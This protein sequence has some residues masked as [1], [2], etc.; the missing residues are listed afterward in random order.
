[1]PVVSQFIADR[2]RHPQ[3]A[4]GSIV[5]D[6]NGYHKGVPWDALRDFC[7]AH[8]KIDVF[9]NLNLRSWALERPWIETGAKGWDAYALHPLSTFRTW[10][11][12]PNWM[13]TERTAI[14]RTPWIQ[15]VGRTMVTRQSDGYASLGFY[16]SRS[17]RGRAILADI[18][19]TTTTAPAGPQSCLLWDLP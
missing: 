8:P 10:F 18:E 7:A 15:G 9:V 12:R 6:P 14:G 2:E 5:I 16:D 1:L 3:H 17:D 13:W 19:R 11:S 4:V